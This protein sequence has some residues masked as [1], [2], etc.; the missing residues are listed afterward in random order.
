MCRAVVFFL[1]LPNAHKSLLTLS[2]FFLLLQFSAFVARGRTC[3]LWTRRLGQADGDAVRSG[4]SLCF[5]FSLQF[6]IRDFAL[7]SFLFFFFFKLRKY[8]ITHSFFSLIKMVYVCASFSDKWTKN[9]L[10]RKCYQLYMSCLQKWHLAS[11]I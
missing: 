10:C 9:S 5:H 8:D 1:Q 6:S 2:P 7:F 4:K 11:G 3:C